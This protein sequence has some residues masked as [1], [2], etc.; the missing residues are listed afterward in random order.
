MLKMIESKE[1]KKDLHI[2]MKKIIHLG[3]NLI[4]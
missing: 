2:N 4:K 3:K 1:M